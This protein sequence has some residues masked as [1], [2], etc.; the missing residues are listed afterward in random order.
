M[1]INKIQTNN[2]NQNRV[3]ET[4]KGLSGDGGSGRITFELRGFEEYADNGMTWEQWVNSDYN[5]E[6]WYIKN[7]NVLLNTGFGGII[8]AISDVKSS[9]VIQDG[10]YYDTYDFS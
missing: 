4:L 5:T 6:G 10:G 9:D 7:G 3:G 1:E 8:V 2:L